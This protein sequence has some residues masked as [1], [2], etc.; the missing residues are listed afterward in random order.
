MLSPQYISAGPI[1]CWGSGSVEQ[2]SRVVLDYKEVMVVVEPVVEEKWREECCTGASTLVE[3]RST[4]VVARHV[5]ETNEEE[6][7]YGMEMDKTTEEV[8]TRKDEQGSPRRYMSGLVGVIISLGCPLHPLLVR[9]GP[10]WSPLVEEVER[11]SCCLS[12]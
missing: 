5:S 8:R 2:A 7:E 10:M 6:V 12:A 3:V 11:F 1:Y 9:S 4:E